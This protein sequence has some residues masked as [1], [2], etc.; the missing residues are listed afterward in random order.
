MAGAKANIANSARDFGVDIAAG[1][2]RAVSTHIKRLNKAKKRV[3][4]AEGVAK[5]GERRNGV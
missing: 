4:R 1:K 5:T 3:R 2:A